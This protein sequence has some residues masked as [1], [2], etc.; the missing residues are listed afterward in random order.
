L[1]AA[2]V[3][4]VHEDMFHPHGSVRFMKGRRQ[5]AILPTKTREQAALVVLVAAEGVRRLTRIPLDPND[6]AA[7]R[8]RYDGFIKNRSQQL[9]R[10][11]EERTGDPD[12]QDG[13]LE[14]LTDLIHHEMNV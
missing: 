7:L 5:I 6:C 11:I 4:E 3:P 2:G 12:L 10:M 8:K 9:R 1:A 13:I 14:V